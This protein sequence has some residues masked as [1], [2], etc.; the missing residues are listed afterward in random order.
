MADNITSDAYVAH[1]RQ[2][3]LASNRTRDDYEHYGAKYALVEDEGTAHINL[4]AP[5]GDALAVTS[6]INNL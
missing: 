3:I 5:N 6:T 1:V 2:L 4:L